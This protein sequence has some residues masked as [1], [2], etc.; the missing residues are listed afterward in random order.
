M[1]KRLILD[2]DLLQITINRLVEE[3][4]ENHKDFQNTVL[5]GLQPRGVFLAQRIQKRLNERLNKELPLGLLDTTFY[6]DDF[7]RRDTPIKAN[8]TDIPFI[9]ED[10]KVILIDDVLFTGR[11]VRAALDAMIAFGRP[12]LVE[13][14]TFID[15]KYTRDLPIQPD[16]VGQ[17]VNTI[18]TQRVLVEWTDQGA[19]NDK[20]WLVTKEE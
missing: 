19:E 15:R 11:T 17:R 1:E 7:R 6:R 18:K 5:I 4:I 13:L 12:K 8:A 10:K 9:I 20:I 2:T 3:L 14:L 16:Y